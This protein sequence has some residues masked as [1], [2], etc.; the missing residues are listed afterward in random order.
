MIT[1]EKGKQIII[2]NFKPI[3]SLSQGLN[4]LLEVYFRL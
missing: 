1:I 4:R 2:E 3:A